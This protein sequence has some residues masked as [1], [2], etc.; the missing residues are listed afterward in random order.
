MDEKRLNELRKYSTI[1]RRHII[2]AVYNAK[3]GHPGGSLSSADIITVLYFNEMRVDPKNPAWEDRDRFVLS[4]GHCSPALYG[5]LAERGFFPVE[6]LL[7]FRHID[8]FLEGHPSMRYVPGVDMST[9]SLGQGIS[10]AV[11]MAIAGKLD[12][13]DYYVYVILGD[14]EM[15]EGQVWEA[16]MSASHYKLNNLIA[17]LDHNHLQIDGNIT[18][19]MSPEPIVDKVRAFGWNVITIDGHDH[20]QISEAVREAKKSGDKPTMIIA[21]TV[22]GKGVSFMENVAEWHGSPPNKEERDR[23]IAELDKI[24]AGL[25]GR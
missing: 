1:I 14:G 17:F 3:S 5:A 11:G 18:E 9:G 13:K 2:E 4:K 8:S 10:A 6:E 19:V 15:Q 20:R 22:K 7:K 25:E 21:E 24:L 16:L 12:K 23:A